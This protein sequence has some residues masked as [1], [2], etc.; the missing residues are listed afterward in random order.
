MKKNEITLNTIDSDN[1]PQSDETAELHRRVAARHAKRRSKARSPKKPMNPKK[2]RFIIITVIVAALL[3]IGLTAWGISNF[4]NSSITNT[5]GDVLVDDIVEDKVSVLLVGADG[6]GYNT[7]TIMLA[8]MDCKTHALSIMSIPRDTRVPNPYG[9]NSYRKINSVYTAKGMDGLIEQVGQITGLPVNFYVKVDFEGFREIIDILGGVYYDVPMR[10]KYSDPAQNLYIDLQQ[11]YQLLDGAKAEQLV[12]SRSQYAEADL[13]RTDVQR[14]FIKEVI[15]QHANAS[16]L[17]KIG[18]LYEAMS[19]YVKTNITM[20]DA[21]KYATALTQVS[22]EDIQMF[23]LPGV[24]DGSTGVS[25]YL[26]DS[27]EMEQLAHDV[28]WHDV[29]IKP[30]PRPQRNIP[31]TNTSTSA[32]KSTPAPAAAPTATAT[33]TESNTPHTSQPTS[34][35]KPTATPTAKPTATP[36]ATSKPTQAPTSAPTATPTKA[37]QSTSNESGDYPDGI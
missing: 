14:N 25:Y 35:P 5:D 22:D 28:F 29:T 1:Q 17:L 6:G 34:T 26:Y 21:L 16:N 10:L 24:A 18:D 11:G 12:R 20:G 27:E 32:P 13:A 19:K 30:T 8:M 9:G 2:K 3:I 23:R 37:P 7:D 36:E 31:T 15:K 33:P 4:L